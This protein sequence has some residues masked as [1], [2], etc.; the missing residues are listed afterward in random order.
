MFVQSDHSGLKIFFYRRERET[1]VTDVQYLQPAV[2][3]ER[4]SRHGNG[5]ASGRIVAMQFL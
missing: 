2:E 3:A 5:A 1:F 4:F